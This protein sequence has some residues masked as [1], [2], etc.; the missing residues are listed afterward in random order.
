MRVHTIKRL[1]KNMRGRERRVN[2][3]MREDTDT[4]FLDSANL[5]GF[6]T[7]QLEGRLVRSLT[8]KE[9]WVMGVL[10]V[11][12]SVA[13]LAQGFSLQYVQRE[14]YAKLAEQNRFETAPLFARRGV[15]LDRFGRTLAWNEANVN[16]DGTEEAFPLRS[17]IDAPALAHI[18][19]YVREPKRDSKGNWWRTE[20]EAHGGIEGYFDAKLSGTNGKAI[21]EVDSTGKRV[22]FHALEPATD[23]EPVTLSIDSELT[24]SLYRAIAAG[25]S[26]GFIGGA[27]VVMDV[28]TGEIIAMTSYPSFDIN[29]FAHPDVNNG[30]KKIAGYLVDKK[31]PLLDRV[32]QGAYLP[33]SI[34]KPFV[35]LAALEENV[36][37]PEKGIV[38]TGKLVIPNPFNPDK[39]SVFKDWK[40]HGWVDMREAIAVS[41]DVYFYQVGGGFGEQRGLGIATL[42]NW[43]TTFGFGVKTG[44]IFDGE[45]AGNVPSPEWKARA[46]ADD[47]NWNV[48]NTYHSA[49]GQYGWLTTPLQAARALAALANGGNLLVPRVTVVDDVRED[50]GIDEDIEVREKGEGEKIAFSSIHKEIVLDG[51]RRAT[52]HGTARA[53]NILGIDI[54]GKTGTAEVGAYKEQM[55]SWVVG[56]WPSKKPKFAFA[57]MLEKAPANT[58]RGAAPAMKPFF[59]RLVADKSPY[60]KGEYP[61]K[62]DVVTE[63]HIKEDTFKDPSLQFAESIAGEVIPTRSACVCAR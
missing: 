45:Q 56:V 40:A 52:D 55:N 22:A 32:Y 3:S 2:E 23:G 53:L 58:L 51:M 24:Q 8:K 39:P 17:Y 46:F 26:S 20:Y 43:M 60:A 19:G 4:A 30:G 6:N 9:V 33:G 14:A 21:F 12:A 54:A 29:E 37:A 49:I 31:Y 59:E 5:A 36:I 61:K 62:E 18:L 10:F 16:K 47:K 41:S 48:G 11:L 13:A 63:E 50:G 1:L 7:A 42:H 44:V 15:I 25:T 57:V 28:E 34:V 35:A 27:G 38:S